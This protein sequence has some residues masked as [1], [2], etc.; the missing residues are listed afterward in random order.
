MTKLKKK[1]L[2]LF[3]RSLVTEE[4]PFKAALPLG[5]LKI[6]SVRP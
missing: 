1:N 2:Y 3:L 4:P 5:I 6:A